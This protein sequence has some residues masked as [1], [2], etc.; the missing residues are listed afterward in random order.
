MVRNIARGP[1]TGVY[2]IRKVDTGPAKHRISYIKNSSRKYAAYKG[3]KKF[4]HGDL[5]D[6]DLTNGVATNVKKAGKK[7]SGSF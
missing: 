2:S 1:R 6:F 3:P 7:R 5:V 4:Q